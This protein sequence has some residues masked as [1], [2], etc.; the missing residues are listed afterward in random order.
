ML[1]NPRLA[2]VIPAL[3]E[4]ATIKDVVDSVVELGAIPIVV[5]DGSSDDTAN[6]ATSAG[7]KVVKH[8]TNKGYEPALTTGIHEAAALGYELAAT[9]DA[10]GQLN[11]EDLLRF[12][13]ILDSESCDVVVGVRNYRNRYAEYILAWY[14]KIRFGLSDPLCGLKLYKLEKAKLYFPF[15]T[16][17]LVGM[18]LTFKMIDAGCMFSQT[19]IYVKRRIGVSR[20]GSSLRGEFNI[21]KA[22]VRV[23]K[24][25][26][27][28][29]SKT[30]RLV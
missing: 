5:D 23:L 18:E 22:F 13:T 26:G 7:A 14:G 19:P 2:V 12:T 25:F 21:I 9:F 30:M 11:P 29:R 6:V 8:E 1:T 4:A 3:N 28:F 20:Y 27:V 16:Q 17:K 15:D 24:L 10:D